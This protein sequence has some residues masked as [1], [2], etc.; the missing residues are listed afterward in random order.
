MIQK[1]AD[2]WSNDNLVYKDTLISTREIAYKGR[3]TINNVASFYCGT[4]GSVTD[5]LHTHLVN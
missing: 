2:G 5:K 1:K 3:E 4:D